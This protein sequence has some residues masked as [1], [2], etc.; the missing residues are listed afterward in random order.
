MKKIMEET[1]KETEERFL[2]RGYKHRY[3]QQGQMRAKQ[4]PR[5]E[6]LKRK[7]KEEDNKI[8]AILTYSKESY[9]I[10]GILQKHWHIL[11][12]DPD[13]RL[14]IGNKPEVSYRKAPSLKDKLVHSYMNTKTTTDWLTTKQKGFIRCTKCKACKIG[15]NTKEIKDFKNK[16]F[17]IKEKITCE[18]TYVVYIIECHSGKRYIGST[19]CPLKK[20]ILEHLRAIQNDDT[21]YAIVKHLKTHHEKSWKDIRY[22]GLITVPNN[23]RGGDRTLK[24]RRLESKM[25]I[26]FKTKHPAGLNAEEDLHVHL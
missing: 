6:T 10:I 5:E 9:Q 7:R 14:K 1:F 12:K 25:I 23:E 15:K 11:T 20:R 13:L 17:I 4:L 16:P 3:I 19:I 22:F 26:K 2:E 21:N 8:R 18:T 24:L